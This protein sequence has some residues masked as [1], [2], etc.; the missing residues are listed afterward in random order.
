MRFIKILAV[1]FLFQGFVYP[2][3][4]DKAI[5]DCRKCHDCAIPTKD[6]PCLKK[7]TRDLMSVVYHMPL[8]IPKVLVIDNFRSEPNHYPPVKFSH[9]THAEMSSMSGSCQM[10]HHYNPAGAI[11]SC[12][13]CH[14]VE[15]KR[16]DLSKIDLKGAYHVQCMN[17]H[18]SWSN[19]IEC[20]TCHN[21][22]DKNTKAA[23]SKTVHRKIEKPVVKLF[24]TS[25][26]K[27][28]FVTFYHDEHT[29]RFGLECS[30]CH[31]DQGC[32]KCHKK[33]NGVPDKKFSVSEMHKKCAKCHNVQEECGKCHANQKTP[34]F[35]HL[36]RTGW[37][38]NKFHA[39]LACTGCHAEKGKFSEMSTDCSSCHSKWT[40]QNFD[41][42]ITG[43]VLDETHTGND[44]ESCHIQK[45]FTKP[46]CNNCHDETY[47]YP[48][49]R[50]GKLNKKRA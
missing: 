43:L 49:K 27:G 6:K 45:D 48:D 9:K 35:N 41:H 23:I 5:L 33:T 4:K 38:L 7:C 16:T 19:E 30:S 28:K 25:Y 22:P 18:R 37:Q 10:C 47:K 15:R 1:L 31:N 24:E 12:K 46:V 17:C 44:C 34:P 11:L 29:N 3:T 20:K 26:T 2:Q 36:T 32:T 50:P 40:G 42:K 8:S 13:K 21:Q 39:K 14:E